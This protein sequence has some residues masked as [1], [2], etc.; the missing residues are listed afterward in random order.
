MKLNNKGVTLIESIVTMAIIAIVF[1]TIAM[2]FRYITHFMIESS[3]I[4]TTSN[5]IYEKIQTDVDVI[6]S[7]GQIVFDGIAP[8]TGK[9]KSVTENYNNKDNLYLSSFVADVI[10]PIDE[11][12]G[13]A[14]F[15][16]LNNPLNRGKENQLNDYDYYSNLNVANSVLKDTENSTD[17]Y[18]ITSRIKIEP[19][20]QSSLDANMISIL[21]TDVAGK[22]WGITS[23]IAYISWYKIVDIGNEN[24]NIYGIVEPYRTTSANYIFVFVNGNDKYTVYVNSAAD[25]TN[26]II[27]NIKLYLH[28]DNNGNKWQH[29]ESKTK[30]KLDDLQNQSVFDDIIKKNKWNNLV[31]ITSN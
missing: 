23:E 5:D 19:S 25:F 28:E 1:C 9:T 27:K 11:Y 2:S 18:Y 14:N 21:N 29:E 10:E 24:Y 31:T 16:L 20:I 3:Q 30:I 26:D 22:Y 12:S 13:T 17:G 7:D 15:Y 6:E 8:I 4:K